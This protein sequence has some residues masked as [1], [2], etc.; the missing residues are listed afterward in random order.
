MFTIIIFFI[1]SCASPRT[2][3]NSWPEYSGPFPFVHK[4]LATLEQ[5]KINQRLEIYHKI[6]KIA[7]SL[8]TSQR[9]SLLKE[10]ESKLFR[11]TETP[12]IALYDMDSDGS[13]DAYFHLTKDK[14]KTQD[15]G[16]IFDLNH[17][18][19]FDYAVFNGGPF[20][21]ESM[22]MGWMNY[23]F[24]DSNYDNEVDIIIYNVDLDDDT[25]A[26]LYDKNFDG[27]I[28]SGEYLGPDIQRP[29]NETED[30]F[31]VKTATGEK[32]I[33]KDSSKNGIK[34][35][36]SLLTELNSMLSQEK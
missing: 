3:C 8:L 1:G 18:G 21:T 10:K 13:A 26:W 9:S 30:S 28:D 31:I 32:T 5:Y 2:N 6:N 29:L 24:I 33:F 11:D 34:E 36:S 16:F 20:L 27:S 12:I 23:H 15:F 17:D 22:K 7:F 4:E 19:K 35:L 14:T 25:N